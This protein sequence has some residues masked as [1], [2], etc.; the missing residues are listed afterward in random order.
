MYIYNKEMNIIWL[1]HKLR[2]TLGT[3][4]CVC[5]LKIFDY[6]DWSVPYYKTIYNSNGSKF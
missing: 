2:L 3:D 6:S 4:D 5:M 1:L